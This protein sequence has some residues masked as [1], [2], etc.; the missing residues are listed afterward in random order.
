MNQGFSYFFYLMTEGSGSGRH[1]TYGFYATLS[2]NIL[3]FFIHDGV[4]NSICLKPKNESKK[5]NSMPLASA[6]LFY[7]Q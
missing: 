2:S 6:K 4:L 3:N 7:T 1:K 5:Y